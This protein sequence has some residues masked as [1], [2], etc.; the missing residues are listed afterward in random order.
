VGDIVIWWILVQL[1]G[2]IALPFTSVLFRWLP[3]RGYA[4]SK[5]LGILIVSYVLWLAA[6]IHILP[7]TRWAII[8]IVVAFA[9]CSFFLFRRY[10]REIVSFISENRRTIVATE[11]IFLL[12]FVL[13]AVIRSYNPEILYTGGE[14]FMDFAFING[15]YRSDYFPPL[16]PWLSN[17]SINNYY[18]GHMIV[19]TLA[20]FSGVSTA[21][22]FNIALALIFALSAIG[23]FSIVYNLV[24]LLKGG[25]NAALSF[26]LIAAIFLLIVGNL[27]GILEML[28]AHGF[29]SDGFWSW[30]GIQGLEQPYQSAHWYPDQFWF[31]WRA[32]RIIPAGG[33]AQAITEFPFFSFLLGDLHA[34][35]LSLPFVLL[36]LAIC[37]NI[38][39]SKEPIGTAWLKRNPLAFVLMLICL[40]VLGTIHTWDLPIYIFIFIAAFLIQAYRRRGESGR[41]WWRGWAALSLVTV[42]GAIFLYLPFYISLDSPA[43]GIGAYRGPTSRYFHYYIIIW[44]L[45]LFIGVS[46]ILSQVRRDFFLSRIRT[47]LSWIR[48]GFPPSQLRSIPKSVSWRTLIPVSLLVLAPWMLWAIWMLATEGERESSVWGKLGFLVPLLILLALILLIVL[49]KLKESPG[50]SQDIPQEKI[51]RK[52]QGKAKGKSPTQ[53]QGEVPGEAPAPGIDGVI[54]FAMLLFFTGLLFTMGSELFYVVDFWSWFPRMNTVFRF[55]YQAWVLFA[56][57]AAFSLYYLHSHWRVSSTA[58]GMARAAWWGVL[59]LL[60]IGAILY[61]LTATPNR[62]SGFSADLT[63]NGMAYIERSNPPEAEAIAWLNSEVKGAPVIVEA[64]GNSYTMYGR[65]AALTGLPTVLGWE[66]V[67]EKV[68]R[69]DCIECDFTTRRDDVGLIYQSTSLE[70]VKALFD[71]YDVGYVYVGDLER[72]KYGAG[73]EQRFSSFMDVA[74]ANEGVTIYKVR[75]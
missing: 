8:L 33:G 75:E 45:F 59:T 32:S 23:V 74:F 9:A 55:Y 69:L 42:A 3:D 51:Q 39:T 64:A 44:G 60:V 53:A 10:R 35:L 5:V 54:L 27:E 56:I 6:S 68:W 48:G 65:V 12:F 62:T 63:L 17:F 26:G 11:V 28:Y 52:A 40:G 38:L 61:P 37:L 49:Q 43:Q 14:K 73:L 67:H 1:L 29:G 70:Q 2:I 7:N 41:R 13:Y 34:H 18:F 30:I 66:E 20:K 58:G 25:F 50:E 31:W 46:F 22:S 21:Y 72:Y 36:A 16:D 57:A 24:R 71:K 19:A 4:F 47:I 15:I